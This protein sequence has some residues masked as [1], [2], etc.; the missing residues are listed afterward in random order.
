[1]LILDGR[2]AALVHTHVDDFLTAYDGSERARTA[3]E[4]V[5]AALY[6]PTIRICINSSQLPSLCRAGAP[7]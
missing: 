1:M 6:L 2:P 5:K 3:L 4:N 7:L